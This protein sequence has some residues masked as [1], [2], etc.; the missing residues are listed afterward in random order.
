MP[1]CP[2]GED[3]RWCTWCKPPEPEFPPT[4][5]T[6]Q[7]TGRE[8]L[9]QFDGECAHCGDEIVEGDRICYLETASGWCLAQHVTTGE[10]IPLR[11]ETEVDLSDL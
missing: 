2:H 1:E 8:I 7:Y 9:A 10:I 4:V 5:E 11:V 6:Y 3:P